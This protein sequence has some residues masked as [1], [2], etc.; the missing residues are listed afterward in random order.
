MGT[1]LDCLV[2]HYCLVEVDLDTSRFSFDEVKN[3]TQM[4]HRFHVKCYKNAK[5]NLSIYDLY[6]I[7][8]CFR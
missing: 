4:V 8:L 3:V 7:P 6:D 1:F 2:E 5:K